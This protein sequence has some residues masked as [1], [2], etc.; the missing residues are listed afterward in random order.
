LTFVFEERPSDSP[1]VESVWRAHSDASGAFLSTASCNWEMVVSDYPDGLSVTLRGPE[2][3]PSPADYP[4]GAE[5]T[6]IRF[7]LGAFMPVWPPGA[8]ADRADLTLPAFSR[9]TFRLH[10][11]CWEVPGFDNADTFVNHLA[12]ESL[13]V[14]DP[15]VEHSLNG[16]DLELSPR[17]VQ[18]RFRQATGLTL[19]LVRQIQRA[20]RAVALLEHGTPIADAVHEAGYFDQAHLTRSLRRFFGRTP[21]EIGRLTA[22]A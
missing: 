11:T 7:R 19:T 9:R 12:K 14:W 3:K 22:I 10:G 15:V 2:T 17:A 5:W 20:T 18:T 1:F 4:A 21:G 6:G 8:V 16:I 13:L